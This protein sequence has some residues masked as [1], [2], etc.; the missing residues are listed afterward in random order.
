MS[1]G[2]IARVLCVDGPSQ[3]VQYVNLD[4][5]LVLFNG[6]TALT[7]SAGSAS[8]RSPRTWPGHSRPPTSTATT[9]QHR[10]AE[11]VRAN[12][13]VEPIG[14][15]ITRPWEPTIWTT[16]PMGSD[17][18][19]GSC[20]KPGP[21]LNRGTGRCAAIGS[22]SICLRRLGAAGY[23]LVALRGDACVDTFESA[24]LHFGD[25]IIESKPAHY[26][27][28]VGS[29]WQPDLLGIVDADSFVPVPRVARTPAPSRVGHW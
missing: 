21:T 22:S 26:E 2:A 19:S 5:G 8:R 11:D 17:R 10:K 13:S 16:S 18:P 9:D 28:I 4:T 20:S 1:L 29:Q 12:A 3:G 24:R 7:A 6:L 27:Q 23:E 25:A 14:G 15:P